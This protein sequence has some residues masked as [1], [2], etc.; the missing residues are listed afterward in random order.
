MLKIFMTGDNHFGKRYDRYPEIRKRLV[1]SRFECLD[2]MVKR[3]EEEQCEL[4]VVTGDL[5]DHTNTVSVADVKRAV[6]SLSEFPRTVLVLPGNHDYYTGEEKV[7]KH[8]E[9]ELSSVEN[10]IVLLNEFKVYPYEFHEEKVCIYPAFCQ[11][12][13]AKENNLG[14]IRDLDRP[15]ENAI[16][17]GIAHGALKGVTPDLNQE[18]FLMTEK[19]LLDIPMDLWLI[20]HT[21]I[22]YPADIPTEES[23]ITGCR[24]FNA[25]TH[26][27]LDLHNR[28]EGNG[29]ILTVEK[30]GAKTQVSAKR[31]VSGKIRFFDKNLHV[32]PTSETA[33]ADTLK[34]EFKDIAKANAIVRVCLTGSVRQEEYEKR[35]EIYREIFSD[36]L[37]FEVKDG[38]LSEEITLEKFYSE[39]AQTSFAA[40]FMER[41]TGNPAE[42]Q[43]A[44][45]LLKE[46]E[47]G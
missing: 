42:M 45:E 38:E 23:E 10:N 3:A 25:G 43:M 32:R 34:G 2:D 11:S 20:G 16:H 1:D 29:F 15:E 27:Q 22:P 46:C 13:H 4:F 21:H 39:Y 40:K 44:Y 33:L 14:W 36:C 41:L 47:E 26:E 9:K 37:S 8:F 12:K 28:T 35:G 30:Q 7:W 24:I 5:F 17:I 6:K 31:F 18:Y 19:E